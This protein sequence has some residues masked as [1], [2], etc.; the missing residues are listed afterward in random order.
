[1]W[2]SDRMIALFQLSLGLVGGF[3]M[4]VIS[5]YTFTLT[6]WVFMAS[7]LIAA[8]LYAV[9]GYPVAI[10]FIY[11]RDKEREEVKKLMAKLVKWLKDNP[12]E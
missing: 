4:W 11:G 12:E 3:A 2:A 9:R 5:R 7:M 8:L 6:F 10:G 1:M